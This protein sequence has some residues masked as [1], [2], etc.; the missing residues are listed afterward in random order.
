MQRICIYGLGAIGGLFAARLAASGCSVSAIA[1][2]ATLDAVRAQGLRLLEGGVERCGAVQVTDDP[3]DLGHQDLVILSVKTTALPE[4]AARIAPLLCPATTV[5]SAMNGIPW[6]FLQGLTQVPSGLRLDTVDPGGVLSAAIA[7]ACVL[8]C[9]THLSASVAAPGQVRHVAGNRLIIGE[10]AGGAGSPR[11]KAVSALLSTAGFEVEPAASI[12]QEIWFKLWGNM[13]M[14]PVSFLTAATGDCILDDDLVRGFMSRC[15]TEAS[16]L[17]TQ[18][19][20]PID[21]DPE[22]RHAVTRKLGAFK[23]SMLQ[24]LQAGK[25]VELDALIGVVIELARQLTVPTPHLE[26]LFGLARL[27][28]AQLGL[29]RSPQPRIS[30]RADAKS[31][32]G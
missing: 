1:R 28:A 5:L 26:S 24:D 8:G 31:T 19:G 6:W 20:L 23:T 10:P 14:N 25:P 11:A 12:Q 15:M 4:V 3:R 29:Y 18:L 27:K 9:V 30:P 22:A 13:T 21:A 16:R 7:P 32:L 17:G 2:G